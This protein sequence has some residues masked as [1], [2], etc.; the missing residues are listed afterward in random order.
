[1]IRKNKKQNE[2]GFTF[3]ELMIVIAIFGILSAMAVP[4][5]LRSLP[6]RRL[7]NATRNLYSDFQKARLLAVRNNRN[8]VVSFDPDAGTYKYTNIGFDEEAGEKVSYDTVGTLSEYGAVRYGCEATGT[9]WN[10]VSIIGVNTTLTNDQVRFTP[11]GLAQEEDNAGTFV[12]VPGVNIPSV[13]YT[14]EEYVLLQSDNDK[15]VCFA[16]TVSSFGSV[17]IRTYSD[18]LWR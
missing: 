8:V 16:V 1:M 12:M 18:G 4:S 15:T 7:T 11:D 10:N 13:G 2:Q 17:K 14:G 3:A 6:E 5:F 9:D